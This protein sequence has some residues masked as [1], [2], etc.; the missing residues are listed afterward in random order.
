M[1]VGQ[2][3]TIELFICILSQSFVDQLLFYGSLMLILIS[4]YELNDA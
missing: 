3:L 4:G 1:I 2:I